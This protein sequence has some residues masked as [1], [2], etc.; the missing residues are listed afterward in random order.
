[1]ARPNRD[2]T[3]LAALRLLRPAPADSV[4]LGDQRTPGLGPRPRRRRCQATEAAGYLRRAPDRRLT[5]ADRFFE[6]PRSVSGGA[7]RDAGDRDRRAGGHGERGRPARAPTLDH[8]PHADQGD[9]MIDVGLMDGDTAS[10]TTPPCQR[11]RRRP[12]LQRSDDQDLNQEHPPLCPQ[13]RERGQSLSPPAPRSSGDPRCRD[14]SFRSP[15]VTW[16]APGRRC[17]RSGGHSSEPRSGARK[18]RGAPAGHFHRLRSR[19]GAAGCRPLGA[20]TELLLE[21]RASGSSRC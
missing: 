6:R 11:G 5:P 21:R 8:V 3:H 12:G 10:A 1:M 20:L 13:T 2:P 19:S 7:C 18:F 16:H 17:R 4:L 14:G 9:S 15:A